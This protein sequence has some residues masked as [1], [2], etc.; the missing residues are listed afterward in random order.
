MSVSCIYHDSIGI[1]VNKSLHTVERISCNAYSGSNAQTSLGV[2]ACHRLVLSLGDVLICDKSYQFVVVVNNGQLLYLVFLQNGS[3]SC[4]V[5]L[6][7]SRYKILACHYLVDL[8]VE[9][10]LES[11]VAVCNDTYQMVFVIN[12]RNTTDMIFCHHGQSLSYGRTAA[13]CNR[14]VNHTVLCTL[15]NGNLA[16]LLLYRHVFVYNADTA[17]AG[18]GY[19]H[20]RLC[21]GVHCGRNKRNVQA[22]VA[23]EL[24]FQL[25]RLWQYFRI[26]WD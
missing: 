9:S 10:A 17:F 11:Q 1:G 4:K 23:R 3:R 14:V 25:Y 7:V 21:H 26:S 13:D 6:D 20:G 24:G 19:S 2:L 8:T 22:D 16:C 12:D 15:N 18:Y 5:C